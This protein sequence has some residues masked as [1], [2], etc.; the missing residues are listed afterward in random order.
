VAGPLGDG[1][2]VRV[3]SGVGF[4]WDLPG[5]VAGAAGPSSHR[6]HVHIPWGDPP[7]MEEQPPLTP[8]ARSSFHF[9]RLLTSGLTSEEA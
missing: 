6:G 1:V 7:Q 9:G 3:D 5:T 8:S 2:Q 4:P